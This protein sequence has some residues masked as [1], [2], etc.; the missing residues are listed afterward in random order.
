MLYYLFQF[1][2]MEWI[3]EDKIEAIKATAPIKVGER[4]RY[5]RR[6]SDL[7]QTQLANL[8]GNDRQYIYKIEKGKVSPS[9]STIAVIAHAL[10]VSLSELFKEI[11]F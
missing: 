4:I 2:F 6:M 3:P 11:N 8:M 7:T 9:I 5:Y 10:N 1:C